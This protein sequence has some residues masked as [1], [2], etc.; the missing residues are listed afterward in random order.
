MQAMHFV[1]ANDGPPAGNFGPDRG[2]S[3]VL[4]QYTVDEVLRQLLHGI[5]GLSVDA[6]VVDPDV[7][8]TGQ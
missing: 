1:A 3:L 4:H 5:G 6:V 8:F 7:F 2:R